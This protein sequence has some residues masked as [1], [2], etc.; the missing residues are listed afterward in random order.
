[1]EDPLSPLLL[2]FLKTI[3]YC[4]IHPNQ[5]W[6]S[7]PTNPISTPNNLSNPGSAAHNFG[8]P[9][10]VRL[11]L[12]WQGQIFIQNRP[13]VKRPSLFM[14]LTA[15]TNINVDLFQVRYLWFYYVTQWIELWSIQLLN[16]QG[17]GVVRISTLS[18]TLWGRHVS[19]TSIFSGQPLQI[20]IWICFRW[21]ICECFYVMQWIELW[22]V[23]LLN[24][25]GRGVVR[26][27][28]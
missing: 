27:S 15:I 23:Q 12:V 26:I 28:T 16:V 18:I 19:W 2:P 9:S 7:L 10:N 3:Q 5:E 11:L 6:Y 13:F 4:I 25:Q 24:V 20:S 22:S 1:M 8:L 14:F 17:R 21:V